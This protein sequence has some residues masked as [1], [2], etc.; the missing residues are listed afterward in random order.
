M[1]YCLFSYTISPQYSYIYHFVFIKSMKIFGPICCRKGFYVLLFLRLIITITLA[2]I[3]K[4]LW[5]FIIF[6]DLLN[7]KKNLSSELASPVRSPIL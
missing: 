5:Q 1:P 7:Y 3:Y 4:T 2:I 6:N